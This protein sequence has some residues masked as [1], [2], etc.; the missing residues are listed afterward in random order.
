MMR[1][2]HWHVTSQHSWP[3][4]PH[5]HITPHSQDPPHLNPSHH[6]TIKWHI[7]TF[8]TQTHYVIASEKKN[9]IIASWHL[10]W[11]EDAAQSAERRTGTPW[12]TFDSP[13][14]QGIFLPESTFSAD[15][16]TVSVHLRV[17][18]YVLTSVSTLKIPSIGSHT[19]VCYTKHEN[20]APLVR[21]G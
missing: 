18:S 14:R 11:G 20:T 10:I 8:S 6:D 3:I 12:V 1:D 15:S 5:I 21:N 9:D 13:V 4:L 17:Q 2:P 7:L 19:F 16:L